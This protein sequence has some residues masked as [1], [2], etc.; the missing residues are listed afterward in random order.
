MT[1]EKKKVDYE[2][3]IKEPRVFFF[4]LCVTFAF[5]VILSRP[6]GFVKGLDIAGGIQVIIAPDVEQGVIVPEDDMILVKDVLT[7]RFNRYGLANIPIRLAGDLLTQNSYLVV[8]FPDTDRQTVANLTKQQGKFSAKINDKWVFNKTERVYTD[9]QRSQVGRTDGGGFMFQFGV[10][11]DEDAGK[12]FKDATKDCEVIG[13]DLEEKCKLEL[14]IDGK[15]LSN[16]TINAELKGR[17]VTSA[18]V[19]GGGTT[20]DEALANM[21]NLQTILSTGALPVKLKTVALNEISPKLGEGFLMKAIMAAAVSLMGV[22]LVVFLRYRR[23]RIVVP[24]VCTAIS[25]T[26][27]IIGMANL[28]G[29]EISLSAIAGIIAAVGTG[30]DTQIIITDEMLRG[31]YVQAKVYG[32]KARL[33]RAF[34]II[35]AAA[36]TT[37]SAM[38]PLAFVGLGAVKGFAITTTLGVL[39]GVIITRPAYIR[40]MENV[41]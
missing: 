20:K 36:S 3:V 33:K 21:K 40:I 18:S 6:Q 5:I 32:W 15:S 41:L 29:W 37:I 34:F 22:A 2:R 12:R 25:E 14:F 9:A 38:V 4:I 23:F 16:L 8:D 26:I 10:D 27:I 19:Q 13:D 1:D 30:V 17:I 39:V 31:E 24:L 7:A 35:F 11:V 28:I